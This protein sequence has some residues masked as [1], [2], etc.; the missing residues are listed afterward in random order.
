MTRQLVAIVFGG[1]VWL[2]TGIFAAWCGDT[3][4]FQAMQLIKFQKPVAM[5]AV[6]LPD[7]DGTPV[8][9]QSFQGKVVLLNFWTTW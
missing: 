9:L 1:C 6:R 8:A 2:A 7:L 5:P 3:A 4:H